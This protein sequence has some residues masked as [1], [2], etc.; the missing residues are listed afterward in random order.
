MIST[1]LLVRAQAQGAR[2]RELG[3][4]H[5]AR[6]AGKQSGANPR[7]VMRAF[8]ELRQ[9][10]RELDGGH[11]ARMTVSPTPPATA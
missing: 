8:R 4:E 7:V 5:R 11:G 10:R 3:V 9:L 6:V 2:V 1:E